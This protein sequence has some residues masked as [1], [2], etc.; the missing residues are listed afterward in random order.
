VGFQHA[1]DAN[2]HPTLSLPKGEAE[3]GFWMKCSL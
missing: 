3:D 1:T 2:P